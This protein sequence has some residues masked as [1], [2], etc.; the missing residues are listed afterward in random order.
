MGN[1]LGLLDGAFMPTM[2]CHDGASELNT[3]LLWLGRSCSHDIYITESSFTYLELCQTWLLN[4]HALFAYTFFAVTIFLELPS[5]LPL[6]CP[7]KYQRLVG[8]SNDISRRARAGVSPA[9]TFPRS[10]LD[11]AFSTYS[12]HYKRSD[13]SYSTS[14]P[15]K[16]NPCLATLAWK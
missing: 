12:S 9:S 15:W 16:S 3:A 10:S 13:F 1:E 8:I 5:P 14:V 4:G 2:K 7:K 6:A 11:L